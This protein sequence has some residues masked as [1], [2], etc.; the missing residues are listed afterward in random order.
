MEPT[1]AAVRLIGVRGRPETGR[2]GHPRGVR[3][4]RF[5]RGRLVGDRGIHPGLTFTVPTG[6]RG[7]GEDLAWR[8]SRPEPTLRWI[9]PV[10]YTASHGAGDWPAVLHLVPEG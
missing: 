8:P 1:S 3:S 4:R 2:A 7:N 6:G 9:G 10:R 5:T